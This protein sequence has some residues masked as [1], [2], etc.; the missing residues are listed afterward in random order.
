[1]RPHSADIEGMRVA[2]ETPGADY[3]PSE[4]FTE[5]L[6]NE[7]VPPEELPRQDRPRQGGR[8]R[9]GWEDI[10]EEGSGRPEEVAE[11]RKPRRPA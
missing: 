11:D 5:D 10:E 6:E 8:G 2:I 4:E 9:L 3:P 1:M 7:D